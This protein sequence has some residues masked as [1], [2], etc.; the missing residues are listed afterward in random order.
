MYLKG[1][2]LGRHGRHERTRLG[3][4]RGLQSALETQLGQIL[5]FLLSLLYPCGCPLPKPLPPDPTRSGRTAAG[6]LAAKVSAGG[7][8][9]TDLL[10]IITL[11]VSRAPLAQAALVPRRLPFRTQEVESVPSQPHWRRVA[12]EP[13]TR[14]LEK[15]RGYP[16]AGEGGVAVGVARR[17]R[18]TNGI[19]KLGAMRV[20]QPRAGRLGRRTGV[21]A[22]SLSSSAARLA[23][24]RTRVG[25]AFRSDPPAADLPPRPPQLPLSRRSTLSPRGRGLRWRR[26]SGSAGLAWA[27]LSRRDA[28]CRRGEG[29][30]V[31]RS[32]PDDRQPFQYQ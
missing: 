4:F 3:K 5:R 27:G 17:R 8:E 18:T 6:T 21:G 20:T 1:P 11:L 13:Q 14:W 24:L 2:R 29:G 15:R 26:R 23:A 9:N 16:S 30:K 31:T 12:K 22:G 10:N 25:T 19:Q 7:F 32:H 28:A